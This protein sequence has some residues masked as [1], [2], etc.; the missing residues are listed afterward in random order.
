M[1][2]QQHRLIARVFGGVVADLAAE[3]TRCPASRELFLSV[4]RF[5]AGVGLLALASVLSMIFQ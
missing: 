3:S 1:T 2:A 5:W 4:M